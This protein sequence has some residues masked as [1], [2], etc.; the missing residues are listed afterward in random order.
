MSEA[1]GRRGTNIPVILQE[2]RNEAIASM[3]HQPWYE[4]AN[5]RGMGKKVPF[6]SKLL[7]EERPS[8]QS[9]HAYLEPA[10][11]LCSECE[12]KIQCLMHAMLVNEQGIWGGTDSDERGRMKSV[13]RGTKPGWPPCPDCGSTW[14]IGSKSGPKANGLTTIRCVECN[15]RWEARCSKY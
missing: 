5:C 11:A 14:V 6:F 9:A 2:A 1:G 4:Q 8:G 3:F 7:A 12:V 13:L 15:Y 10:R